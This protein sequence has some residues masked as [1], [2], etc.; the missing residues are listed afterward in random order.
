MEWIEIIIRTPKE[1]EDTISGIFYMEGANGLEIDDPSDIEFIKNDIESWSVFDEKDF[2]DD[3]FVTIKAYFNPDEADNVF[4]SMNNK[5]KAFENTE[6]NKKIVR[7]EDWAENWKQYYHSLSIGDKLFI[8][9][10]WE[11][12]DVP[13]GRKLLR[14]DPGMAFGTGTHE[15]TKLCLEALENN[16][17]PGMKVLD[18]GTGSGILAIASVLLGA[19]K[20]VGVDIDSVSVK[21]AKENVKLNGLDN[22]IEILHGD[23]LNIPKMKCDLLISNI[24]VEILV[25][26][27]EDVKRFLKPGGVLIISGIIDIKENEMRESLISHGFEIIERREEKGW[28]QISCKEVLN[29]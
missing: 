3:G 26:L 28:V 5:I 13:D 20:A 9:P 12:E 15:T 17:K 1:Y 11:H 25:K 10:E 14:I 2:Q 24:V 4:S 19:D 7:E 29:G 6:I 21:M 23:L 22:N 8:S 16:I 18:I 27:T